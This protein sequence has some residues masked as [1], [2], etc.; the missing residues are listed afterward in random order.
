M[1]A[2]PYPPGLIVPITAAILREPTRPVL[3]PKD[4]E[5]RAIADLMLDAMRRHKGAGIAAPQLGIPLRMC[6]VVDDA[7]APLVMINP[8]IVGRSAEM[9]NRDE[10]CLSMAGVFF[11]V[12]RHAWVEVDFTPLDRRREVRKV[13]GLM[14][15]CAQHEIDHLDG[16]R[17]IDRISPLRRQMALHQWR[18]RNKIR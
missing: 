15:I 18:K 3:D 6:V 17:S 8:E 4:A 7:L 9:T 12:N 5:I 13:S 14:S 10:G 2:T 1:P 16:I 11:P